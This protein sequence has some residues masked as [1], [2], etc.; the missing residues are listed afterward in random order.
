MP[1]KRKNCLA[2]RLRTGRLLA[3]P[4]LRTVRESF[5]H[6]AQA[7][8]NP[9]CIGQQFGSVHGIWSFDFSIH[10]H[11]LSFSLSHLV[12]HRPD[13]FRAFCL[14]FRCLK[15]SESRYGFLASFRLMCLTIFVSEKSFSLFLSV[16][17]TQFR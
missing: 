5:P 6:T 11:K 15:Y 17:N 9:F 14:S 10:A 16:E 8:H 3:P 1:C 2:S 7:F 13:S 4:R 12:L